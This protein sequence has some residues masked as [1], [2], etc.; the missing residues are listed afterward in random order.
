MKRRSPS[1][2]ERV[3]LALGVV[4]LAFYAAA[5]LHG[6]FSQAYESWAFDRARAGEPTSVKRFVVASA[7]ERLALPEEKADTHEWS[8]KRTQQ[9]KQSLSERTVTPLGR[10]D[11]PSVGLRVIVLDGTDDWTLNRAVGR[12]EGTAMP[13]EA[14][15]LGIAGHRDGFFRPLRNLK[16]GEKIQLETLQGPHTYRV[17]AINIVDPSNVELLKPTVQPTLTL[18]TC[19]PFYFI[20]NAPKRFVVTAEQFPEKLAEPSAAAAPESTL[21]SARSP[22]RAMR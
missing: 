16:V 9:Y 13:G 21:E 18:V 19:Y 1:L 22:E 11:I 2:A 14:G 5:T 7:R 3:L 20:G 15:N 10:L 8:P 12:I 6:S 4:L 17:K